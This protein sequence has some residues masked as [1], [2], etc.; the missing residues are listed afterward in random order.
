MSDLRSAQQDVGNKILSVVNQMERNATIQPPSQI[1]SLMQTQPPRQVSFPMQ[2][3]QTPRLVSQIQTQISQT[4]RLTPSS[5]TVKEFSRF[6][7]PYRK[8][9]LPRE[10]RVKEAGNL[11]RCI[12]LLLLFFSW[13][14]RH[15]KCTRHRR[16][17]ELFVARLDEKRVTFPFTDPNVEFIEPMWENY[18]MLKDR[19]FDAFSCRKKC[20]G[21]GVYST[22][23][24]LIQRNIS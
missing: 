11:H 13:Q 21:D 23:S 24:Y 22:T 12:K 5:R 2:I 9:S 3:L 17:V 16:K 14:K 10:I 19:K 6:F 18:L 7:Y 15:E 4:S 1:S 20:E 8:I